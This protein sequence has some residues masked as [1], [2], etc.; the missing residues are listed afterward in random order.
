[1]PRPSPPCRS[2]AGVRGRARAVFSGLCDRVSRRPAA[3][4]GLLLL[5]TIAFGAVVIQDFRH[6]LIGRK[7]IEQWVY[8]CDYF[9]RHVTF[10]PLPHI[11]LANDES[12][13][14]Y[15]IS[16]V[17]RPWHFESAYFYAAC[18]RLLGHG[19]WLQ[20]Y[21]AATVLGCGIGVYF[22]LR[23]ECGRRWALG[24]A[25]VLLIGNFYAAGRY[26]IHLGYATAHWIT[27]NLL[28]DVIL[29]RRLALGKTLRPELLLFKA[30]AVV[31]GLGQ[32]L[33]YVCGLILTSS[34]IFGGWGLGCMAVR[35]RREN[36]SWLAAAGSSLTAT[37]SGLERRPLPNALLL[38]AV[39][40]AMAAYV[41]LVFD[42]LR[43][44]RQFTNTAVI[45]TVHF[46]IMVRT[47]LQSLFLPV[48]P[49]LCPEAVC[50]ICP[51]NLFI[52]RPGLFFTAGGL[53]GLL[54]GPSPR[55]L[56]SVAIPLIALLVLV[57][58]M[59]LSWM[60]WVQHL[61]WFR[62]AREP[63]R[64]HAVLPVIC[65]VPILLARRRWRAGLG[66]SLA[67]LGLVLFTIE[68]ATAY[69]ILLRHGHARTDT[70]VMPPDFFRLAE[71]VADSPGEAV[72]DW[73][74]MVKSGNGTGNQE[75][76][77]YMFHLG[78]QHAFAAFHHKKVVGSYMGRLYPHQLEPLVDAGWQWLFM[79]DHPHPFLTR[80]QW[81]D[82]TADQWSFVERFYR[83]NDFCGIILYADL[84]PADTVAGFHE[85]FGP[86]VATATIPYA[87][88]I[89]FLRK[90]A[91]WRQAVD[92][93]AGRAVSFQPPRLDTAGRVGF[94]ASGGQEYLK[95]GWGPP[96]P[97]GRRAIHERAEVAFGLPSA[98]DAPLELDVELEASA[99]Q[100]F[101]IAINDHVI[102]AAAAPDET[103]R[104]YRI[105]VD[106]EFLRE[107]NLL[108]FVTPRTDSPLGIGDGI[109]LRSLTVT[110]TGPP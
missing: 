35:C 71:A 52:Y 1:M 47:R 87:G 84:L 58:T 6:P 102:R 72:L 106:P 60:R 80:G 17:F 24:T 3:A 41:P 98:P 109:R 10:T 28:L 105:R 8:Q 86:P 100:P 2:P 4:V 27:L 18:H 65:F 70:C 88:R 39:V 103:H 96:E 42:V 76:G 61:P 51:G 85:R 99:G 40:A 91:A 45:D 49:F 54:C 64:L 104:T 97:G 108:T 43:E 23:R 53:L 68:A 90:P 77:C 20:V 67:A 75:F 79:P 7:D 78:T 81:R 37:W 83:L 13:Y 31:S 59:D 66:R 12:F 101:G 19:P 11:G 56:G 5:V 46:P 73:P 21:Y 74:F 26:P 93:A 16:N 92:P 36:R 55:R 94:A 62:Y 14:P 38:V 48:L 34:L 82:F 9:C 69:G 29:C 50:A 32:D 30:L 44:S 95:A 89:Q 57:L 63:S 25:L 110:G 107:A 22:L 33:G 15:G